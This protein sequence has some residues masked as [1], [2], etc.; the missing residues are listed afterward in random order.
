MQIGGDFG[1]VQKDNLANSNAYRY[2]YTTL[3][4]SKDTYKVPTY[5]AQKLSKWYSNPRI[6]FEANNELKFRNSYKIQQP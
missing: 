2:K 4:P 3:R 1:E 6:R 5:K